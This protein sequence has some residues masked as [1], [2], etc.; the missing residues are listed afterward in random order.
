MRRPEP[1]L[2][3]VQD[4]RALDFLA[5]SA[6]DDDDNTEEKAV[7]VRRQQILE[8]VAG[9]VPQPRSD[10]QNGSKNEHGDDESGRHQHETQRRFAGDWT[11]THQDIA[12][13]F[14]VR[15]QEEQDEAYDEQSIRE[16]Q[17]HDERER[18]L[19]S[20]VFRHEAKGLEETD[21]SYLR[22]EPGTEENFQQRRRAG[23]RR[24]GG[25]LGEGQDPLPIEN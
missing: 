5:Q 16:R 10:G 11:P 9:H 6:R 12:S 22:G 2:E 7:H 25:R 23:K 18:Q 3:P 19:S 20:R 17:R 8:R 1:L 13:A 4:E 14:S 15:A 24:S 21:Y